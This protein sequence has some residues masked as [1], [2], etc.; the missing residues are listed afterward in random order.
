MWSSFRVTSL[1]EEKK[2]RLR[3]ARLR[4][5]GVL[6]ALVGSGA[7]IADWFSDAP[8]V[9]KPLIIGA[10]KLTVT[11]SMQGADVFLNGELI[12]E[13]PLKNHTVLAGEYT[14]KVS[15]QYRQDHVDTL[16]IRR[17]ISE[18]RK[19][20]QVLRW[21]RLELATNPRGASVVVDGEIQQDTTPLILVRQPA[22]RY[23]VEFSLFGRDTQVRDV[24]VQPDETT[25]VIVELNLADASGLT[26]TTN[27]AGAEVKVLDAPIDYAP[28]VR[29]PKGEYRIQVSARGYETKTGTYRLKTGPN[30]I[31]VDLERILA[32]LKVSTTPADAQVW[33]HRRGHEA[34]RLRGAIEAAVGPIEIRV[35][36]SGYRSVVRKVNLQQ[37][38]LKVDLVL[39][40]IT[41]KA[42]DVLSD[43]L[44]NGA[45]APEM[46]VI[47]SGSAANPAGSDAVS[48]DEPYALGRYEI[49]RKQYANFA[50]ATGRKLPGAK[51]SQGD[52]HP[53]ASISWAQ[54][55]AY[56]EWLSAETSETYR[57]PTAAEWMLAAYRGAITTNTV[58]EQGN[59]ADQSMKKRYLRWE[60][61]DCIDGHVRT[62]PVGSFEADGLGL[63]DMVGNV[64]EWVKD[65]GRSGCDTHLVQGSAW[66]SSGEELLPG[67]S[68][69]AYRGADVRGFRLVRK[70]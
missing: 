24:E 16:V 10:G 12:G 18:Q 4:T 39:H 6:L 29:L 31:S 41:E 68:G 61:V 42:G 66:D 52:Q 3:A 62:A 23:E 7:A 64:S 49:T 11:S 36:R 70:L 45:R 15:H 27:P 22:G 32:T 44:S 69:S 50:R 47:A 46:V 28:G 40:Q 54:A 37:P 13:T 55:V 14:L 65:C 35:R 34:R 51:E 63:F 8:G 59:V 60:V 43:R 26:V 58:C 20:D 33:L 19:V 57:L 48:V 1:A 38:G 17:G 25:K 5:A 67:Y 9:L 53:I 2:R 30:E 21:G 56:A